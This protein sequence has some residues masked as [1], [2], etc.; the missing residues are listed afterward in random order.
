MCVCEYLLVNDLAASDIAQ[1]LCEVK[2]VIL[3][4]G[5]FVDCAAAKATIGKTL[6]GDEV[7]IKTAQQLYRRGYQYALG[8]VAE[9]IIYPHSVEFAHPRFRVRVREYPRR[10]VLH[11]AVDSHS[12]AAVGFIGVED[13]EV[14]D[15]E[16]AVVPFVGVMVLDYH[17]LG[18]R[19]IYGLYEQP[20][21]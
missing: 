20:S 9:F 11:V 15:S 4:V 18:E 6:H 2:P 17:C 10:R 16:A 7:W 14:I 1:K 3:E 5:G 21:E 13:S 8:V 12:E 19:L